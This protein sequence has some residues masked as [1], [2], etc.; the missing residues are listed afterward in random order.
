MIIKRYSLLICVFCI[1]IMV[2]G[3]GD[4]LFVMTPDEEAIITLYASKTVSKFNKNQSTGICN[5]RVKTGE[6]ADDYVADEDMEEENPEESSEEVPFDE[7]N[8]DMELDSTEV[9]VP[10]SETEIDSA[11][12][13][14]EFT[15]AM[16]I[17]GVEFSFSSF[18]V[19]DVFQTNAYATNKVNGKKYVVL[20]I[21]AKNN[22]DS[23]VD[24]STI[25]DRSYSLKIGG[26]EAEVVYVPVSNNL[27]TY[28]GVMSAGAEKSFVLVFLFGESSLEDMSSLELFVTSDG[29]TRGTT[30]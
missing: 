11:D 16:G 26:E 13:G 2:T 4:P 17:D 25:S 27:D 15:D 3:C 28:D 9:E 21:N 18:D 6:L 8:P 19:S 20:H 12:S 24:F 29:T 14:Y 10:D 23:S 30:I 22:S 7:E 1:S 5:A